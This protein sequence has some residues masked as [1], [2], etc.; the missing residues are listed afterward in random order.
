M[1]I[2]LDE[3]IDPR[4]KDIL[5]MY[6]HEVVTVVEQGLKGA[7]DEEIAR[8]VRQEGFCLLTLDLGFAN[9]LRYPPEDYAGI[10]VLRHPRLTIQGL[11][12]LVRQVA[13][14][15]KSN[16][17]SRHLWIVDPGRLRVW[18]PEKKTDGLR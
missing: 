7:A 16:D 11:L 12:D 15:L 8:A 17:P 13:G 10:V 3:N 5:T 14:L 6:G 1:R 2:K 4:A 18:E 9:V